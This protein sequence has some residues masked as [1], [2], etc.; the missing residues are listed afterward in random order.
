MTASPVRVFIYGSCVSRDTFEYLPQDRFTLLKYIARQSL[1]SAFSPPVE[2]VPAA[3]EEL[4]SAFQRRM[5]RGDFASD[6]LRQIHRSKEEIDLL[7]WDLVDE[8]LGVYVYGDGT[9]VT[10]T[11]ELIR[12]GLDEEIAAE[13]E[14]LPFGSDEHF[15]RWAGAAERYLAFLDAQGLRN[16]TVLLA[17]PWAERA[18]SGEPTPSSFGTSAAEA[19]QT[20]TR[21]Y[22]ALESRGVSVTQPT[23]TPVADVEHR[24]GLAPFHYAE[25]HYRDVAEALQ[26]ATTPVD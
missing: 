13:A 14:H 8:R 22:E 12:S 15:A 18:V 7:L 25:T 6:V 16:R 17:V 10:R 5:Q 11:V 26:R 9:V 23:R 2:D 3:V 1:I 21:Y 20:F 4:P 19:N 24:W